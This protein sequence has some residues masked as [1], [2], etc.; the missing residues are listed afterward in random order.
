MSMCGAF[1]GKRARNKGRKHGLP[2]SP[3]KVQ[4]RWKRRGHFSRVEARSDLRRAR[5]LGWGCFCCL[6]G[7]SRGRGLSRGPPPRG[8]KGTGCSPATASCKEW[9]PRHSPPW[10]WGSGQAGHIP[11]L[12]RREQSRFTRTGGLSPPKAGQAPRPVRWE[13]LASTGLSF[14]PVWLQAPGSECGGQAAHPPALPPLRASHPWWSVEGSGTSPASV[15]EGGPVRLGRL[16]CGWCLCLPPTPVEMLLS[17]GCL[18]LILGCPISRW[19]ALSLGCPTRTGGWWEGLS[20][21]RL[22]LQSLEGAQSHQGSFQVASPTLLW[23]SAGSRTEKGGVGGGEAVA[24]HQQPA[25]QGSA[26]PAL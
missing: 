1:C 16:P 4:S 23:C 7:K 20:N 18:F 6:L 12:Q 24:H 2:R 19:G 9:H 11:R 17:L 10:R 26:A 25:E 14:S 15:S 8:P 21:S 13:V 5:P 22:C 3:Q